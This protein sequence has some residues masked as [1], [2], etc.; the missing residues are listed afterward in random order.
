[1]KDNFTK[2]NQS[3]IRMNN[4]LRFHQQ[5]VFHDTKV[6]PL[7]PTVSNCGQ[8]LYPLTRKVTNNMN[9]GNSIYY[10]KLW[11]SLRGRTQATKSP[12]ILCSKYDCPSHFVWS[13]PNLLLSP[14]CFNAN[15]PRVPSYAP[16]PQPTPDKN[17]GSL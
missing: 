17:C 8:I 11:K 1:M 4:C 16:P 3:N 14:Y 12:P 6:W 10:I 2:W 9:M 13:N 5:I 15:V 7:I